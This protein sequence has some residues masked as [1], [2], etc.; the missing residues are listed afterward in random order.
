M[1]ITYSVGVT[2]FGS[3]SQATPFWAGEISELARGLGE[4]QSEVEGVNDKSCVDASWSE[5]PEAQN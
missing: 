3:R 4:G 5:S 1:L 2:P